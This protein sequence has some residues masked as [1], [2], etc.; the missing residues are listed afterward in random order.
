N[1]DS[2]LGYKFGLLDPG[3]NGAI[4]QAASASDGLLTLPRFR[5]S[6]TTGPQELM[7]MLAPSAAY[8]LGNTIN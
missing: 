4:A 1:I 5:M 6:S 2:S 7:S 3:R 8:N